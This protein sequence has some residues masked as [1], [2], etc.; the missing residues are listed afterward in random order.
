MIAEMKRG[1]ANMKIPIDLPTL[2]LGRWGS[3][4]SWIQRVVTA[5]MIRKV[6]NS[7]LKNIEQ[8]D[9]VDITMV[10]KLQG[11]PKSCCDPE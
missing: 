11:I 4:G 5:Y 10:K 9:F 1:G 8:I 7:P 2:W 6:Y 3:F